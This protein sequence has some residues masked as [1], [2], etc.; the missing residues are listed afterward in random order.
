MTINRPTVSM[1]V[2][3]M[4]NQAEILIPQR[5]MM[6]RARIRRPPRGAEAP[7]RASK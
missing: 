7:V 5:R 1:R 3:T 4:A 6:E 2:N